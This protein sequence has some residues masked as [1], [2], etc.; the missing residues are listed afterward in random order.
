MRPVHIVGLGGSLD[1]DSSSLVALQLA[2]EGARAA[3][4][5]TLLLDLRELNLPLYVHGM[6][7][8]VGA[9]RLVEA[10][11]WAHGMLWSSPL[12]H[13]TMSGAMKNALDWLELLGQHEPP[14][15]TDKVIGLVAT[16]GG[17]QGLQAINT[18]E[19]VVRSLRGFTLPLTAPISRAHHAFDADGRAVDPLVATLLHRLGAELVRTS[20]R[21]ATSP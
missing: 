20:G 17:V 2:L 10:T 19:Y 11:A 14:Y 12:Y 8:P 4:A 13:G 7:P 1:S 15:L 5:E 21:F 9:L 3:G 16:A 6:T 18:M